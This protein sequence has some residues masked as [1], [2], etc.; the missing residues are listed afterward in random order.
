MKSKGVYEG[1]TVLTMLYRAEMW[2]LREEERRQLNVSEM[3]EGYGWCDT[4]G[5]DEE[6]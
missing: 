5:L 1:G 6:V 2:G 3:S 4:D